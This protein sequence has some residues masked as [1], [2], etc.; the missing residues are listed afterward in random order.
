MIL[1]ATVKTGLFRPMN[2]RLS[3]NDL[4]LEQCLHIYFTV[5]YS[6]LEQALGLAIFFFKPFLKNS[7]KKFI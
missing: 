5:F 1:M 2:K 7:S 4:A 3:L 6:G